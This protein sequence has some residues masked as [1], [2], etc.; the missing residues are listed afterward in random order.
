[1]KFGL[2]MK[3]IS[4]AERTAIT[5]LVTFLKQVPIIDNVD[6]SEEGI[7]NGRKLMEYSMFLHGR[8]HTNLSVNSRVMASPK[9]YVRLSIS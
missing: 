7:R 8:K 5:S 6:V 4:G 9:I 2:M 1:M 3:D